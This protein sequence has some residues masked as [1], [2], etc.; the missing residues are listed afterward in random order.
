MVQ[1]SNPNHLIKK[2]FGKYV[3]KN[4]D[5]HQFLLEALIYSFKNF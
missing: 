2:N 4:I 5:L 1:R 3:V